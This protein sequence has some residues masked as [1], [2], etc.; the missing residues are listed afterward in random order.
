M[1]QVLY[2][3]HFYSHIFLKINLLV[4][5]QLIELHG[6]AY[7]IMQISCLILSLFATSDPVGGYS[8]TYIM[9]KR[10]SRMVV[11][12]FANCS[13]KCAFWGD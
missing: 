1:Q 7:M 2:A 6:V 4:S 10:G 8:F 13:S 11:R 9:T 5:L 3:N 12:E